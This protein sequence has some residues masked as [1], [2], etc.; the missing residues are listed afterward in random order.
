MGV[1]FQKGEITMTTTPKERAEVHHRL[2]QLGIGFGQA[3]DLR[4]IAMQLHRWFELECGD[5]HGCIERDDKTGKPYW[6][7]STTMRRTPI[8]DRERGAMKRLEKIMEG[9]KSAGLSTTSRPIR[10]GQAFTL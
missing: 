8:A 9:L 5:D 2:A 4:R 10:E 7:N 6:L 1:E 3:Y